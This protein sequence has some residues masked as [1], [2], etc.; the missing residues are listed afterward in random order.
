MDCTI[1]NSKIVLQDEDGQVIA[2]IEFPRVKSNVCKI[3]KVYSAKEK[4]GKDYIDTLM[5]KAVRHFRSQKIEVLLDNNYA[6]RWFESHPEMQDVLAAQ[7]L[8]G[9]SSNKQKTKKNT[10]TKTKKKTKYVTKNKKQRDN[11]NDDNYSNRGTGM[12]SFEENAGKTAN[13]GLKLICRVLQILSAVALVAVCIMFSY[14]AVGKVTYF[15]DPLDPNNKSAI[16]FLGACGLF[17]IFCLIEFNWILSRPRFAN[18]GRV[19]RLDVGRGV[20]VF[21]LFII[22]AF[23]S[24]FIVDKSVLLDQSA[25]MDV[26]SIKDGIVL[27]IKCYGVNSDNITKISVIGLIMCIIRRFI[28]R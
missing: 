14:V 10:T 19:V 3:N 15:G 5:R 25:N 2:G 16:A 17:L 4:N 26:K 21:V 6:K 7:A 11:S 9:D 22:M 23:A 13:L 8:N 28:G 12:K 18:N 20:F 27:F 1:Y 24:S